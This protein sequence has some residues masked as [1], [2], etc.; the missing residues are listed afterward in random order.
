MFTLTNEFYEMFPKSVCE[1]CFQEIQI[2]Y[3]FKQTVLKAE[4]EMMASYFGIDN[5]IIVEV[6]FN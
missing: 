3:D 5:G 1:T 6:I 4:Q 2:C